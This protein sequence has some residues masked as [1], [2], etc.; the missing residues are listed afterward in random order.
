MVKK[1]CKIC[2]KEFDAR[3]KALTCSLECSKIRKRKYNKKWHEEN[4]EYIKKWCEENPEYQ[5]KW[6]EENR[7]HIREFKKKYYEE[8]KEHIRELN[9]KWREKNKEH[10]R[11]LDK[12]W[13][14]ENR[15]YQK[16][17]AKKWREENPE[18]NKKW[19]EENREYKLERTKKWREENL[20]YQKEYNIKI[21]NELQQTILENGIL[22]YDELKDGLKKLD[23]RYHK[24]ELEIIEYN[25]D[26]SKSYYKD[27][28]IAVKTRSNGYCEL[29]GKKVDKGVVHHLYNFANH[30]E[31]GANAENGIYLD[32]EIHKKFHT[33]K[34]YN[35]TVND[36]ITFCD[37]E[38]YETPQFVFDL[39]QKYQKYD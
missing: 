4:P 34:G 6:R 36:F 15:E 24:R 39:K 8:N 38:G 2:G 37:E 33:K 1:I 29:T 26:Y 25:Q 30:M 9:K 14:E 16:E 7:E 22:T 13:R 28:V 17:Y 31:L 18:Y 3:G 23:H 10:K 27:F 19:Y 20:E 5:R 21:I 11:E 32:E 12:K 35:C